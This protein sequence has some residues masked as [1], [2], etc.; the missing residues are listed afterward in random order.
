MMASLLLVILALLVASTS[1]GAYE[2]SC[3][4]TYIFRNNASGRYHRYSPDIYRASASSRAYIPTTL[5]K[6]AYGRARSCLLAALRFPFGE[7]AECNTDA[8]RDVIKGQANFHHL[9]ASSDG[10]CGTWGRGYHNIAV[11]GYIHG[12]KGCGGSSN[13]YYQEF[14]LD[15][16]Y[17]VY[18]P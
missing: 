9:V 14:L 7:A 18:C 4:A 10:V 13:L 17:G 5:R 1:V 6:R 12:N 16:R 2:R 3:Q 8:V 15:S 11:Y